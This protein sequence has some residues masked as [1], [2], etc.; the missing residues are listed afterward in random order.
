MR[1]ANKRTWV[2]Y[3]NEHEAQGWKEFILFQE[4]LGGEIHDH[5]TAE[6]TSELGTQATPESRSKCLD[7]YG[8]HL[9]TSEVS[10]NLCII[11]YGW[12][13]GY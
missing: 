4:R 7:V 13:L 9:K 1:D 2:K 8:K 11:Q 10:G 3:Y 5:F 6:L 12:S